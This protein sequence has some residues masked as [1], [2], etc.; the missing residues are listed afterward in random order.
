MVETTATS[1]TLT[2]ES[3]NSEPVSYY[4]VQYRSKN[5]DKDFQEIDGV[6]ST[7]YSI[8]GLSPFTEYE[9]RVLASNSIGRG[10][11]SS[12]VEI[13]TGEQ[14]PSTPPL[15]VRARLLNSTII[16]L[17]WEPPEEPN[18]QLQGYRIYYS[19]EPNSPLS[20]WQK[21]NTNDT[22]I[23]SISGLTPNITYS[24]KI[25]GFTSVGDGPL[26]DVLQI[27]TQQ[28]GE[29]PHSGPHT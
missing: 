17:E 14:A 21:K 23:T 26:S 16:L 19:S 3:G 15:H 20:T 10:P 8:G 6:A 18:G 1:V 11:P 2:W 22:K 5:S 9:F 27:K 24:F 29:K 25:L 28:G 13:R 4:L 7:R 12:M